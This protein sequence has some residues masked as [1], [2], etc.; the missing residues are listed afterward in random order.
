[1]KVFTESDF[2]AGK[3]PEKDIFPKALDDFEK[4]CVLNKDGTIRDGVYGGFLYGS[5]ARGEAN[6]ASDLDYF[7]VV[8]GAGHLWEIRRATQEVYDDHGV[9]VQKRVLTLEEA[10]KG[11]HSLQ[12][13]FFN[14]LLMAKKS[15]GHHGQDPIEILK[16]NDEDIKKAVRET[17]CHYLDRLVTGYVSDV[18]E[19]SHARLL[20]TILNKPMYCMREMIQFS[21]EGP[22]EKD[23]QFVDDFE[24]VRDLFF[25]CYPKRDLLKKIMAIKNLRQEYTGL[26]EERLKKGFNGDLESRNKKIDE[27]ILYN[28]KTAVEIVK[29]C[30][31]LTAV[32][33]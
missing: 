21:L 2:K 3:I 6:S 19:K 28:H 11:H 12:I 25:D 18:D 10:Q 8:K 13:N 16:L 26:L 14:H 29:A 17:L 24:G 4:S 27:T 23:G 7:L 1:M 32:L 9:V 22:I 5:S 20:E 30:L 33:N 31:G 15:Y